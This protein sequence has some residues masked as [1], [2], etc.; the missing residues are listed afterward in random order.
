MPR[1]FG[2]R[3]VLSCKWIMLPL[4][5]LLVVEQPKILGFQGAASLPLAYLLVVSVLSPRSQRQSLLTFIL[6]LGF[7]KKYYFRFIM[8]YSIGSLE[9]RFRTMFVPNLLWSHSAARSSITHFRMKLSLKKA[10][11]VFSSV[12]FYTVE[13]CP[14]TEINVQLHH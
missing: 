13:M 2:L 12:V 5:Q 14:L 7:A 3:W 6:T 9:P 4:M 11:L 8:L 10:K 1:S